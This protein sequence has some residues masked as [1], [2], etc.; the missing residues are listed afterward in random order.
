MNEI[1]KWADKAMYEAEPMQGGIKVYLLSATPDPL[2]AIAAMSKIYKGEVVRDLFQ[3]SDI[4]RKHFWAESQKTHLRAPHEA[5]DFHFL[6]EGVSRAFTHQMVRQRTAVFAQESLRFAVKKDLIDTAFPPSIVE[7]SDESVIWDKAL[8]SIE[9]AYSALIAM[10]VPAEDARGL[11]PHAT[12]TRLHYKTNL[13]NLADHAGNR[14]CTQA[15]FEWRSVMF[16]I[17]EAIRNYRLLQDYDWQ[18]ETIAKSDLFRP[19]CY[20][21]GK[22]PFNAEFDRDC[23]IRGRVEENK[24]E[25]IR[26]EEWLFDPAAARKG[27]GA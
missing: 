15:Q 13:R 18:F 11:L 21:M 6:I 4:E 7:E 3:V 17:V 26:D 22:C 10:G 1:Q 25:Q 27:D 12:P 20:Q 14:L 2:G 19:V 8:A 24:F 23:T 9:N 5:V 16:C